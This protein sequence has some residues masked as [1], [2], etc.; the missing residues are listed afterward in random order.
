MPAMARAAEPAADTRR[1]H[2]PSGRDCMATPRRHAPRGLNESMRRKL[3]ITSAMAWEALVETHAEQA[4]HFIAHVAEHMP[5]E[6]ALPRYLSEIDI[7]ATMAAAIRTRVLL[8]FESLPAAAPDDPGR[9]RM[10]VPPPLDEDDTERESWSL[11]RQPQRVVRGV[12]ERQRRNDEFDRILMLS[13]ARAEE[14]VIETHVENA[15]G[16]VALLEEDL[17]IDRCVQQYL[18]AVGLAGGRAQTVF[19]R[20]MARLADVHLPA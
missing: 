19:Q 4:A 7:G 9:L 11:L 1:E 14:R 20:T 5:L 2:D 18:G 13:L 12:R 15:I 17:P 6:D 10:P 3:E 8:Q 16:F